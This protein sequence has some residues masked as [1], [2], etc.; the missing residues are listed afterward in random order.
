MR[1]D[2]NLGQEDTRMLPLMDMMTRGADGTMLEMIGRQYGLSTTQAEQA[3]AALMPA[4]S[5]G[6]KRNAH[7]PYGF[8]RFLDALS[9]GRHAA[10]YDNPPEALSSGG[11]AEGNA[12][13]G[14]L[15]GS[16]ELSRA[17]AAQAAQATGISQSILKSMLPALAP[18][19]MGGLF[20]QLNGQ[21]GGKAQAE[22]NPLGQ[23]LEQMAGGGMTGG[24]G[25]PWGK[26][27]EQMMG[28]APKSAD[29][30][31]S[32]NP[33]GQ[34]MEQMMRGGGGG[35][36]ADN[37][38]G[39]I[40][41]DMLRGGRPAEAPREDMPP[42]AMPPEEGHRPEAAPQYPP[43]TGD[44]AKG[45]LGDLFGEMFDTGVNMQRDYQK[46]ME[47]VFDQFLQGMKR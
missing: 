35:S 38:L 10:Y 45:G 16:K 44:P 25:N 19:I 34:M 24:V 47:S 28:G 13:L 29:Q 26:M 8:T 42:E 40:F 39:Q 4:F 32:G 1:D 27:L 2:R 33:W 17:V 5:Q 46:N 23:M 30:P 43:E 3:I 21:M 14:H 18:M 37:P 6:L 20:K 41:N 22:T 36:M 12:I 31:A 9:S 11:M 15:F 7:D